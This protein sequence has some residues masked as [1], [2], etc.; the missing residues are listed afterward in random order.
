MSTPDFP[1]LSVRYG[2]FGRFGQ[3]QGYIFS[4]DEDSGGDNGVTCSN[5]EYK[6]NHNSG[7]VPNIII[8]E[9]GNTRFYMSKVTTCGI[10]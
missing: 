3:H 6:K 2:V 10:Y 8:N 4:D 5:A 1:L 9:S 7:G